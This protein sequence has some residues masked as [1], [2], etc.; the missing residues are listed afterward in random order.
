METPSAYR[1]EE[2]YLALPPSPSALIQAT[3][4]RVENVMATHPRA[5]FYRLATIIFQAQQVVDGIWLPRCTVVYG[6]K[7]QK[8]EHVIKA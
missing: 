3:L 1:Q 2:L 4:A 8:T 5:K 6:L 7:G